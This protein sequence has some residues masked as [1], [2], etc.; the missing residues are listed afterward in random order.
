MLINDL[1]TI[2]DKNKDENNLFL[3]NLLK[4][5]LQYYFLNFIYNSVYADKFLFKGGTCLRFC[6]DLPRLSEDLDFDVEDYSKFN[7]DNFINDVLDYFKKKIKYEEISYKKSGSNKIL[8]FK[9]PILEKIGFIID[10]NKP[11]ENNLFVRIDFSEIKGK[12]FQTGISLKST[13]DFSFIIK[14]YSIED[15]FAG[16][17]AAI[18]T[19]EK[20]E[21]KERQPR[22]KGRDYY[23]I[24]WLKEKK[25]NFNFEYLKSLINIKSK[26][27]LKQILKEKFN[28]AKERKEELK[29]DLIPFFA[30]Q[31]FV[32]NFIKNLE[33]FFDNF[34]KDTP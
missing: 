27:E 34:L 30:Q 1:K 28:E 20:F 8:Y 22:F 14:R 13:W 26:Q 23:D 29:Q 9:F 6:F 4:E 32:E 15:I 10:K 19:R 31:E 16:K 11:S 12:N 24:F 18:L 21:D 17:I 2:V 25:V 33:L 7:V 3:R 5:H